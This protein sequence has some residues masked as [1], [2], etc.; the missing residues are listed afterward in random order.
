MKKMIKFPTS[1]IGLDTPQNT[2]ELDGCTLIEQ[3]I[4]STEVRGT[5]Y[6][7]QHLLLIVLEGTVVLTYGKQEY[8]V[9]KNDM[10]LLKKATAVKYHKFG[11]AENDNIYDSLMF[12][13][14]DDLLK[15]FL[16]T[17]EIKVSK[18]EG[19][20]KTGVYPMNECLVA[21]AYSMKPYFFDQSVV[22]P[23]QLRLK[24]MELLYDVAECNRNMFLQILQLHEPVRTDIRNVVEQHYASPVSVSELAYL[25]G[26]SL[27][28]F[29][30]DFQNIYN[31]APATWIREKRLEKAKDMLETTALSVSDI[32]YS[33]GFENVSHFSRI[34][35]EFHGQ[36]PSISR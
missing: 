34:Y 13:I 33:L 19:E 7:E 16:S 2:L 31:V 6:L 28:S 32:C 4:H 36:A 8:T 22:H 24:I 9:G 20:I 15:S 27:S 35:K 1:L 26:R 29:K 11:N 14:K 17:S 21:F 18:P 25:S 5:M 10:I 23:G 12:S 30:R 3:C